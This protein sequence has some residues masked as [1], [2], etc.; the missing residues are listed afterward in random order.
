[1]RLDDSA[2]P[3]LRMSLG[4]VATAAEFEVMTAWYAERLR[5]AH[6]EDADLYVLS[7]AE[8]SR[9]TLPLVR[10]IARWQRGLSQP[11][12]ERCRLSTIIVPHEQSRRWLTTMFWFARP[13][14]AI[15]VVSSE[16]DGWQAIVDDVRRRGGS[17]PPTPAWLRAN[18]THHPQPTSPLPDHR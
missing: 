1:M 17:D 13:R 18:A 5:R 6:A 7:D 2:W 11:D 16:A 4:V 8:S 9:F 15:A 3:Y 14:A 10:Y 12:L